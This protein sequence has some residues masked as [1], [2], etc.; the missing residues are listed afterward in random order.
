[1]T[2]N[3][4]PRNAVPYALC[5]CFYC[6][7]GSMHPTRHNQFNMISSRLIVAESLDPAH[8]IKQWACSTCGHTVEEPHS[9]SA[10]E[11]KAYADEFGYEVDPNT[12]Q[13]LP[14]E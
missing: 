4:L 1:M 8:S 3:I 9:W 14:P 10:E 7:K 6:A 13:Y 11:S 5:R 2:D 12:G